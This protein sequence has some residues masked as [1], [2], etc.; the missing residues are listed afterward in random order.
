M[1]QRVQLPQRQFTVAG[2]HGETGRSE[3][4]SAQ[5]LGI[6]HLRRQRRLIVGGRPPAV[7]PSHARPESFAEVAEFTHEGAPAFGEAQRLPVQ[8]GEVVEQ[9]VALHLHVSANHGVQ[10]RCAAQVP[11]LPTM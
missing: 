2:Q 3:L 9:T 8:R 10:P 1:E 7:R 11:E 6:V 5:V 4:P